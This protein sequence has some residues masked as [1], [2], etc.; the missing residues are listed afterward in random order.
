VYTDEQLTK[1]FR[2]VGREI[3]IAHAFYKLH[4]NLRKRVRGY[5]LEF[6]TASNFWGL[7][8]WGLWLGAVGSLCRAYD[9]HKKGLGLLQLLVML[10]DAAAKP[11]GARRGITAKR[12][13]TDIQSVSYSDPLAKKLLWQRDNLY[14]HVNLENVLN[15]AI[16]P[17]KY[18]LQHRD[19]KLL[20]ARAKRII[21]RYGDAYI[22]NTWSMT[23]AR[24]GD[25]K[26]VLDAQKEATKTYERQMKAQERQ[27]KREARRAAK[28]K[29]ITR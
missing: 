26:I 6:T 28:A 12:F 27:C 5:A 24:D 14:S 15:D 18:M 1:L 13:E 20:L 23:N 7:T 16:H 17:P 10:R 22:S 21:N 11:P 9:Q 8:L 3:M 2:A 29:A 25:Y 4:A 19:F